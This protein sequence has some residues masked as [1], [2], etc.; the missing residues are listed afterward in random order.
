MQDGERGDVNGFIGKTF[1]LF[2]VMIAFQ[3]VYVLL[4]AKEGVKDKGGVREFAAGMPSLI[5]G[6]VLAFIST[7][8]MVCKK[9][10][11]SP[12]PVGLGYVMWLL[13]TVGMTFIMGTIAARK[14]ATIILAAE[15]STMV[16]TLFCTFFGGRLLKATGGAKKASK[17]GPT[18]AILSLVLATVVI[19]CMAL[20]IGGLAKP[21]ILS[22]V[23]VLF[24][25]FFILD[26]HLIT[27]GNYGTF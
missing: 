25:G 24:F 18:V 26:I 4:I 23:M 15:I 27:K 19:T 1:G 13:F 3:L 22:I 10:S 17:L 16:T 11:G 2:S 9:S 6:I 21:L 5:L 8:V 12:I 7:A 20:G 14:S